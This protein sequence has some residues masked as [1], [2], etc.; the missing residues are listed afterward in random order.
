MVKNTGELLA[1]RIKEVED[2]KTELV[3]AKERYAELEHGRSVETEELWVV[4]DRA[5]EAIQR[6]GLLPPERGQDPANATVH[7]YAQ[8]F[9]DLADQLAGLKEMLD[10]TL[11]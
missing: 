4:A 10:D 11:E 6:L 9:N 1:R 7:N 8:V 2:L 5:M 3:S